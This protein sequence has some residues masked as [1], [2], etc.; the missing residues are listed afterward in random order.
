MPRQWAE[1]ARALHR[2]RPLPDPALGLLLWQTFVGAGFIE[3]ERM[4]AYIEKAM[5]EAGTGTTWRDPDAGFEAAFH[6][7]VDAGY[8]D[9]AVHDDLAALVE[10][11]T[12]PGRSNALTQKIIALTMPGVP[13]IYQGTELWDDSL[14]DPDNRRLVDYAARRAVLAGLDASTTP[15]TVDET[16]AAKLH[17]VATAL[18]ARRDRPERFAEYV[19]L[20]ATG[21]AGG[22]LIAY[23]RGGAIT[24]ATRLPVG[25][26]AAGGWGDT[27]VALPAGTWVDALTGAEHAGPTL[28]L[29]SALA[30]YPVGLLLR[31]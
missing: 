25:L 1:T 14:V 17:L 27:A 30:T 4:H 11:V 22:H 12:A 2:L 19:A 26:A 7:A 10:A 23:D 15:P 13:D 9:T 24:L 6:D 20:T 5:R 8:D 28:A 31:D 16:G 3:R 21:A 29:G 18:R